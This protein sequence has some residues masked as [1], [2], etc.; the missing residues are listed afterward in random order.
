[1]CVCML[2]CACVC[3]CVRVCVCVCDSSMLYFFLA[4]ESSTLGTCSCI[5]AFSGC[6]WGEP[7]IWA[8]G[9]V[10]RRLPLLVAYTCEGRDVH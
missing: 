4:A 2:V 5:I 9:P 3:V 8:E 7:P 6:V 10:E 1:V